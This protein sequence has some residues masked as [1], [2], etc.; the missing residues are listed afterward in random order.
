MK[1]V[2]KQPSTRITDLSLKIDDLTLSGFPTGLL[3]SARLKS[4]IR[5]ERSGKRAQLP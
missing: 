1:Q 5:V 3:G 4:R 2:G